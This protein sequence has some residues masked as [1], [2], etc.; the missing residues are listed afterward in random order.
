MIS[1]QLCFRVEGHLILQIQWRQRARQYRLAIA[2]SGKSC[3][4]WRRERRKG[5]FSSPK[6]SPFAVTVNVCWNLSRHLEQECSW[7]LAWKATGR[8]IQVAECGLLSEMLPLGSLKQSWCLLQHDSWG[9]NRQ[10]ATKWAGSL[11]LGCSSEPWIPFLTQPWVP[12]LYRTSFKSLIATGSQ[13]DQASAWCWAKVSALAC[14]QSCSQHG[15]W[16]GAGT[17]PHLVKAASHGH[18]VE[19][20][21]L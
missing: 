15:C 16:D 14:V 13:R 5:G 21:L 11:W 10:K 18:V 9:L 20:W 2:V 12:E 6:S 7:L 17:K 3:V 1:T 19:M 4:S 8:R